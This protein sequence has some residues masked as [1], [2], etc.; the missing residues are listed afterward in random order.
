MTQSPYV[1]TALTQDFGREQQTRARGNIGAA[2]SSD[3][4]TLESSVG[5]LKDR[6]AAAEDSLKNKKDN[7]T[8]LIFDAPPNKTI[9]HIVQSKSCV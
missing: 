3:L 1:S 4:S 2:S 9:T 6:V 8:E 7:Q 5:S